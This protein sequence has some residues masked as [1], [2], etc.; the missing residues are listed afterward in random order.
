MSEMTL[1]D[2]APIWLWALF[3]LTPVTVAVISAWGRRKDRADIRE[4]KEHVSNTHDTNL[5]DDIDKIIHGMTD[6]KSVQFD[7]GRK[8]DCMSNRLDGVDKKV[9]VYRD[10]VDKFLLKD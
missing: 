7:Q 8:L 3:V 6:I 1:P 10:V 5:R 2:S 4:V 9:A